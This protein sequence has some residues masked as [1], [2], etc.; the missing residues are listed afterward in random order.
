MTNVADVIARRLYRAGC[1]YAFGIPGGEVLT[2]IK[3]LS[4]AG[5][6]FVLAKHENAAGFMAE[7]TY[8]STGAPAVLIATLGPGVANAANVIANAQQ[9]RVPLLFITGCVDPDD[10]HS[11]THQIF[12]HKALM[13]AVTKATF[14]VSAG[15]AGTVID[16]A[17]AIAQDDPPGPVHIDVPIG[18]AA[19]TYSGTAMSGRVRAAPS[20]PAP[21]P[22]LE[23]ARRLVSNATRPVMIAGLEI[24]YQQST[25]MVADVVR[26]FNIPLITTYK[27]KGV[28]PEDDPL[29]LGAAGLSPKADE[30]L[31]PLVR[32]SDLVILVGYD[33]IEMRIGWRDPWGDDATVIELCATPNIHYMHQARISFIG[34]IGAGLETLFHDIAPRTT[35]PGKTLEQ[36]R[37]SLR[38]MFP[39][40]ENWGPAAVVD[41][42]RECLSPEAVVTADSGAHRILLS[43]IWACYQPRT[44]LQSTGLCTMGCAVPLAL[45]FKLAEPSR[46]VAAFVGDAGMEM[47]LGELATAR[48]L[49]I[50]VIIVVFVDE[51]LAL[52]ELKQR[53]LGHENVG[54][55]FGAT[56]FPKVANALGGFGTLAS[57]R[58]DL[59][60]AIAAALAR[61]TFTL[62]ACPIG[63]KAYDGRF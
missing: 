15:A 43:Q 29:S 51:S 11:Y 30:I 14:T 63:K 50:P 34:H 19:T 46:P 42:A 58:A 60:Q 37:Q 53:A 41:A 28:I 9:D 26:R 17:L 52:I 54:V 44:L 10:S 32:Q 31:L 49:R 45:G 23:Q 13:G 62:I 59:K 36:A 1:R 2:L 22:E 38:R 12:D 56:D 48:D 4:D 16:K 57:T 8:H 55:D 3:A 33:P 5:I 7:G 20:A 27:A 35:W 18:I 39:T 25:Q 24:L 40:D 21:S 61:D 6:R 47:V